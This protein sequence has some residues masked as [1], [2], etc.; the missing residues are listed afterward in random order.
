MRNRIKVPLIILIFIF[1][2]SSSATASAK[3][4]VVDDDSGADFRL[5]Q[6]AVYNSAPGDTIIVRPGTYTENILVNITGLT[7]RSGSKNNDV[8]VKPLDESVST[9]QIEANNITISGLNITGASN[10]SERNA[11]FV[12][13]KMNNVTGNTIENGSIVLG[14]EI[15]G[16][17]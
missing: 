4:I 13:G 16:N 7:V 17:L 14:S 6:E 5:I 8:Q 12:Y 3:E 1:I 10:L 2:I 9:F 15:S 11:I